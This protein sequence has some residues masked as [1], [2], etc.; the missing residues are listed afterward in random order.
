MTTFDDLKQKYFDHLAG[1]DL[2]ALSVAELA[3]Y[4]SI[5]CNIDEMLKPSYTEQ[6]ANIM[7]GCACKKEEADGNG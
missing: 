2:A 7:M 5:L 3:T 6:M 1:I 4:G